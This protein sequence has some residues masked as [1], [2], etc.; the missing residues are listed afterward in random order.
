MANE[1]VVSLTGRGQ[2]RRPNVIERWSGASVG[3]NMP[4]EILLE[5]AA[6]VRRHP[7]W[8]ARARLTLR[9]LHEL[10]LDP[11]ARVLDTGCGWG[12]TLEALERS[13][14]QAIGLDV[15]RRALERLDRPGRTLVRAD[16]TRPI[17]GPHPVYDAVLALDVI[18]HLDDDRAAVHRLGTLVQP[19]GLLVVSVPA[20]PALFTEFDAIQG[21]RRRYLPETLRAAFAESE[22]ELERIFWWG[23]W[24]VPALRW[25]RARG[26][27]RPGESAALVYRRYLQLPP[28]PLP[29]VARL[30]FAIEERGALRGRLGT[31]T[32][33]FAVAR[34]PLAERGDGRR[35]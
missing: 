31:G 1:D 8:Q 6:D 16:L 5:L 21:H 28:W 13:G 7:W 29:R 35:G 19:G 32:S 11:P 17:E 27:A 10:G 12:I 14:Y 23:R 33:L 30:A 22:L 24:L 4:E 18:E 2:V 26:R 15:S 3:D 9:L 20:L 25:Q 34:R